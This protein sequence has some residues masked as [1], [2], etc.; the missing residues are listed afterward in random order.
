MT[1]PTYDQQ[2]PSEGKL[3]NEDNEI[4]DLQELM[5]SGS[6]IVTAVSSATPVTPIGDATVPTYEQITPQAKKFINSLNEV[7]DLLAFLQSGNLKVQ[8]IGGGGGAPTDATYITAADETATL[9]NSQPLSALSTG[10]MSVT[11]TTGI[12]N[13]RVFTPTANQI[14]ITNADGLAGNPA[15][16]L[17]S[18]LITPGS[19]QAG[20]T[21]NVAGTVAIDAITN[22]SSSTSATAVMTAS[23]VQAAIAAG[24]VSGKSLRG[25]WDASSGLYPATGGS[26]VGGAVAVGDWW[27]ITVAGT[28]G[29]NPVEIGD[30]IVALVNAPGQTNGNWFVVISKVDSVFGRVGAVLAQSGDYSFPLIS[31]TAAVAQGGT[32]NTSVGA[33]GTFAYSDGSKYV[34]SPM[35]VPVTAG[36][37]GTYWRSNGTDIL[38]GA[39]QAADV[40]TLNQNTSG[41]AGSVANAVTFNNAGLGDA[42]GATFNGS[43]ART[44]SHNTIGA[45]PLAGSSSIVTV[46]TIATGTW[47]ATAIGPTKGGTGLTSPGALGNVLTSDGAGNWTS[48]ASASSVTANG[49]IWMNTGNWTGVNFAFTTAYQELTSLGTNFSLAADS[50][51][52]AM[53]TDGRLKYTG[54]A[55]ATMRVSASVILG[56]ASGSFSAKLYKNGVAIAGSEVYSGNRESPTILGF[57]V[58]LVATNDYF[59]VWVKCSSSAS[60]TI[61]SVSLGASKS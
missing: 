2:E 1:T 33:A 60:Q 21:F 20:T 37:A 23:A 8:V 42:S 24:I 22:S 11:T 5:E 6:I 32:A 54:A 7:Y 52:F 48:A 27:Y 57:P 30:H 26:G 49:Y 50:N 36:S 15:F 61:L 14:D 17:A 28:L 4:L 16:S 55:I 29:T 56:N 40:P 10:F 53:T 19:L 25:G 13:S 3:L 12:V 45:S 41:Q 58:A 9:P 44:I 38:S 43:V 47:N 31:G 34:F 39:I 18:V 35:A 51:N 59:S 46:G